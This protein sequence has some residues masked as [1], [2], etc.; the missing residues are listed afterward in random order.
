[1]MSFFP[2]DDNKENISNDDDKENIA[3]IRR[4]T[5]ALSA[6]VSPVKKRL[7]QTA[8]DIKLILQ[9]TAVP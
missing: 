6:V 9:A 4:K 1:M 8:S 7:K 2:N 3:P 5:V